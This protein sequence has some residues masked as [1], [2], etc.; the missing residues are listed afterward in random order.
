MFAHRNVSSSQSFL[1]SSADQKAILS[2]A[3]KCQSIDDL[4]S[5]LSSEN[6]VD[7]LM[8]LWHSETFLRQLL[9]QQQLSAEEEQKFTPTLTTETAKESFSEWLKSQAQTSLGPALR[10]ECKIFSLA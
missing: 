8:R 9:I 6:P 7:T 10:D 4:V 3:I 1:L 2:K 5:I